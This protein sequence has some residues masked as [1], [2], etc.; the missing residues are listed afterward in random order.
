MKF[1][2]RLLSFGTVALSAGAFVVLRWT[3][4]QLT[5]T[6]LLMYGWPF[7]L[8]AVIGLIAWGVS[9]GLE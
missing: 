1:A 2:I 7:A 8:T 3:S 5:E 6:Q 9:D 4:P